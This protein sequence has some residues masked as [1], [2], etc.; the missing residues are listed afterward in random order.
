MLPHVHIYAQRLQIRL[1]TRVKFIT[2][3]ILR[4]T[5]CPIHE[6]LP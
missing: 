5:E 3:L 2:P 4:R 6:L 1:I